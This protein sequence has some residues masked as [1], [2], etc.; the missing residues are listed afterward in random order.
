MNH[1]RS[2]VERVFERLL[3]ESTRGDSYGTCVYMKMLGERMRVAIAYDADKLADALSKKSGDPTS[4]LKTTLVDCILGTI[5]IR[6]T[7]N[8][9]GPCAGAW[10][11][12]GSAGPKYGKLVYAMGYYMSPTGRLIPDR[13]SLSQDAVLAWS[14]V[15]K[16]SSIPLDDKTHPGPGREPFHDLHHTEDPSDDCL[17]YTTG[18]SGDIAFRNIRGI[19][20]LDPRY[21]DAV[22]RAYAMGTMGYDID[23]MRAGHERFVSEVLTSELGISSDKDVNDLFDSAGVLFFDE[24]YK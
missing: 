2:L 17:I 8:Q 22:N 21:V 12:T 4:H 18:V 14:K 16:S 20:R 5:M 24:Y 19:R 1:M 11:V 23:G 6:A 3:S 7:S 10:E 15:D 13:F 9:T